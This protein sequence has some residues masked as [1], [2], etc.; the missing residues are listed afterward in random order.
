MRA[1]SL[2]SFLSFPEYTKKIPGKSSRIYYLPASGFV[3]F[4]FVVLL[5]FVWFPGGLV[6]YSFGFQITVLKSYCCI[7]MRGFQE[8]SLV[9]IGHISTFFHTLFIYSPMTLFYY[10]GFQTREKF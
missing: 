7:G 8:E 4:W 9:I 3:W 5:C 6:P 1:K 2:Q 10:L